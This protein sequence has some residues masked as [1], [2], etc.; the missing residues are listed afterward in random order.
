MAYGGQRI[1]FNCLYTRLFGSRIGN[2]YPYF[3]HL[4][5]H[6]FG[7]A[8]EAAGVKEIEIEASEI[9]PART[10]TFSN[11]ACEAYIIEPT[12]VE[13]SNPD[14]IPVEPAKVKAPTISDA[15]FNSGGGDI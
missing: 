10:I 13:P 15:M 12:A 6:M 4:E 3:T 5:L 8:H 14:L 2:Q 9:Y 7:H 1:G 11:A